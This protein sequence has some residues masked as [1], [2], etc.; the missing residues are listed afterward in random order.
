MFLAHRVQFSDDD[1]D[2][3][4]IS[5]VSPRVYLVIDGST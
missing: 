3:S 5:I 1:D 2:E 4:G